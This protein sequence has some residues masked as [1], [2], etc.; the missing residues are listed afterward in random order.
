MS[1]EL[2]RE[3]LDALERGENVAQ[4]RQREAVKAALAEL[5]ERAP[6]RSVE[7]RIPPFA[8]VQAIP[9]ATHR[10]GTPPAVV[11]TDTRTW[12]ALALG[13]ITW[14]EAVRG[15]TV[16]ASGV[17]SDLSEYLPLWRDHGEFD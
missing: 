4:G 12:L 10:R 3:V 16:H 1:R 11:E 8:A 2:A 14:D 6:G 15:G 13:R 5:V 9:G 7:I 17:R